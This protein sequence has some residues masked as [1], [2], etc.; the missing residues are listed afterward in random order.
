MYLGIDI[1]TSK[2]G[3]AA[4][5][6]DGQLRHSSYQK[7][8]KDHSLEQKCQDFIKTLKEVEKE[9][10]LWFTEIFIEEPFI[11][12]SGGGSSAFTVAKLHTFSGMVR[13]AIYREWNKMPTMV[14]AN[15]ARRMAGIQI[16]RGTHKKNAKKIVIDFV[17][18]KYDNF[19]Y[20]ETKQGNPKP[21]VDDAADAIVIALSGLNGRK[22]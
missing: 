16:K 12:F 20:E 4:I 15:T 2:C 1:S 3:L 11:A 13:Y 6:I 14:N 18:E 5:T 8:N 7:F 22:K 19:V 10:H 17:R 9:H 21:G